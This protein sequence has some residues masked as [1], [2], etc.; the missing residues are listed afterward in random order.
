VCDVSSIIPNTESDFSI[1]CS[2]T[3]ISN[4]QIDMRVSLLEDVGIKRVYGIPRSIAMRLVFIFIILVDSVPVFS[5][6]AL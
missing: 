4:L 2:P 6:S 5:L 1:R 3:G